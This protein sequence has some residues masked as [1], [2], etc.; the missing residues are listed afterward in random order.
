MDRLISIREAS[1]LLSLSI[2]TLYKMSCQR[3]IPKVKVNGRCLFSVERLEEWIRANTIEPINN[4][5]GR[6]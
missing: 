4:E 2:P 3:K 6:N 1:K 5:T